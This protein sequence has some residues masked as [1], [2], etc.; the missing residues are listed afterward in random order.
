MATDPW[1]QFKDAPQ[2]AAQGDDPWAQFKDADAQPAE[3]PDAFAGDPLLSNEAMASLAGGAQSTITPSPEPS[4]LRGVKR[5]LGR[6]DDA[7]GRLNRA[8][9]AGIV[10]PLEALGTLATG[11]IA[12]PILGTAESI[13]AGTPP[14]ESFA[15][16]TYQ[17]RTESGKAQL[18]VLGALASPLTES[19]TDIALAPLFAG[20]SRILAAAPDRIPANARRSSAGR[21]PVPAQPGSVDS[22]VPPRQTGPESAK[23]PQRTPR[24]EEVSESVPSLEELS[25][26]RK[27][28]YK[29][30]DDAGIVVREDSLKGVKARIVAMAKKEG[31]NSKL[32][33]DS[34]AALQELVKSKG[35]LTLTEV[36]TL[37]KI[38]SDAKGS[39][40]PADQRIAGKMVDELDEYLDNLKDTDVLAGDA[41]KAKALK[42]ARDLYSREKKAQTINNLVE[43]AKLSAPNFSASGLENALRTEFRNLAKNEKQIR[44]FTKE[45]QAAIRKVAMGG[46]VENTLRFIGKFAPTGVVSGTLG[47]GFAVT[48][49]G[50][51]GLAIPIAGLAGRYGANRMTMKNVNAAEELMRRGPQR[52]NEL[53]KGK[54]QR[55]RNALADF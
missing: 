33:P 12:A 46:P 6:V 16:Y 31:L 7:V 3:T 17:P 45:E 34:A 27:A 36:E 35:N 55:K 25:D 51:G 47:G 44:R 9:D 54:E 29:K 4:P 37:R 15:R 30:A 23:T 41:V 43:R 13:V 8:P 50:P 14:E 53:A 39:I 2:P 32:H 26:L 42:E 49:M 52:T 24:L 22:P 28:A 19:G 38:A 10:G 20:E 11:A 40:K 21:D 18:G 1:A 5:Y 48:T